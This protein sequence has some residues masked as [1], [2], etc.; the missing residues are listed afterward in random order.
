MNRK[1]E[2]LKYKGKRVEVIGILSKPTYPEGKKVQR[3]LGLQLELE[4]IEIVTAEDV[5]E[6]MVEKLRAVE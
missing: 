1:E 5:T 3:W 4:S 2:A 6:E